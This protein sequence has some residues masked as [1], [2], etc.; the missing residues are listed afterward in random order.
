MI[1]RRLL[2]TR[3]FVTFTPSNCKIRGEIVLDV[4]PSGMLRTDLIDISVL[5]AVKTRKWHVVCVF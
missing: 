2:R 4:M 5:G 3:W 1:S